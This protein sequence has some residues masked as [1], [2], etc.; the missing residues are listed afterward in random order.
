[1][2]LFLDLPWILLIALHDLRVSSCLLMLLVFFSTV[3]SR[4]YLFYQV[5]IH[6][7]NDML[8]FE[9]L[10]SFHACDSFSLEDDKCSSRTRVNPAL[11]DFLYMALVFAPFLVL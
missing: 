5:K 1:M 2:L 4:L 6:S 8:I 10:Y 11:F 3:H 7:L 9:F